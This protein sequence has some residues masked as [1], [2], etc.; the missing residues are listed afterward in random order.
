MSKYNHF[1][2]SLEQEFLKDRAA[3]AE[4]A[5]ALEKAEQRKR[6]ADNYRETRIGEKAVKG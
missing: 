6:D 3:Y 1:A 4:A 2:K 5:D